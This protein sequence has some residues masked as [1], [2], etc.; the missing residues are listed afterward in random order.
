MRGWNNLFSYSSFIYLGFSAAVLCYWVWVYTLITSSGWLLSHFVS[1]DGK[2]QVIPM[3]IKSLVAPASATG[4][5]EM[6]VKPRQS[7]CKW[8]CGCRQAPHGA[9]GAS[10]AV[11]VPKCLFA[12]DMRSVPETARGVVFEGWSRGT[13]KSRCNDAFWVVL[14]FVINC[15]HFDKMYQLW[16]YLL[17]NGRWGGLRADFSRE[18]QASVVFWQGEHD[19]N[20]K[21]TLFHRRQLCVLCCGWYMSIHL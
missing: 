14:V 15:W 13:G 16:K 18:L 6:C 21:I 17:T 10:A 9:G 1:A 11:W 4:A 3:S 2:H 8:V 20:P 19:Q 7:L 5:A 12:Q